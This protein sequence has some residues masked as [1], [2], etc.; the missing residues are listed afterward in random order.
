[1]GQLIYALLIELHEYPT[2]GTLKRFETTFV[3]LEESL[4]KDN[5]GVHGHKP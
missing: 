3:S 4:T 1:M 5:E 2:T